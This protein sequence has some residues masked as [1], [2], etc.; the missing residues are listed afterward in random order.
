M[1]FW[2]RL[3]LTFILCLLLTLVTLGVYI[4]VS[5]SESYQKVGIDDAEARARWLSSW[6]A[7]DFS[8]QVSNSDLTIDRIIVNLRDKYRDFKSFTILDSE[9]ELVLST[10]RLSALDLK[11]YPEIEKSLKGSVASSFRHIKDVGTIIVAAPVVVE[12]ERIAHILL[13]LEHKGRTVT[14]Y[15]MSIWRFVVA[16]FTIAL[17][18]GSYIIYFLVRLQTRSLFALI[19]DARA[20]SS[21][22]INHRFKVSGDDEIGQLGRVLQIMVGRLKVAISSARE[23]KSRLQA[24][25]GNMLDGLITINSYHRV[26]DVNPTFLTMVGLQES[27]LIGFDYRQCGLPDILVELVGQKNVEK[28]ITLDSPTKRV[29]RV[30]TASIDTED[31]ELGTIAICEDITRIKALESSEREFTQYIS[32]ELK[33]PLT[34]LYATVETLQGPA[35]DNPEARDR[36][37]DSFKGDVERLKKLVNSILAYQRTKEAG[38]EHTCFGIVSLVMD[39]H[40][41][42]LAYAHKKGVHLDMELPEDEVRVKASQDRITQVLMN[43]LDNAVRFTPKGGRVEIGIAEETKRVKIWV[44]DTGIGIPADFLERMGERFIKIPREDHSYDTQ[45]GLGLSI[46]MEILRRHGSRLDIQSVEGKGTTM[47][48]Y[49][50]KG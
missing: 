47:S 28:E 42:F 45:V 15:V 50:R 6:I 20:I 7:Y 9:G 46:C 31:E 14:P 30:R 10:A 26:I 11:D 48:F 38:D 2:V 4:S 18:F 25:F 8:Y 40:S 44:S 39:V 35:R 43:L 34:S 41:K 37:L 1:S 27:D 19:D 17:A 22:N 3:L 36:F 23:E 29:L 21:G 33:T 13:E 5:I 24:I 16:A 32:H 49:L 12:G